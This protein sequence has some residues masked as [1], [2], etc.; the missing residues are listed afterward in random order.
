ARKM[1]FHYPPVSLMDAAAL[2][3][4]LRAKLDPLDRLTQWPKEPPTH[5]D[6]E[7]DPDWRPADEAHL[8]PAA[9]LAPIVK[10]AGGCTVLFTQRARDL[11][12]QG[13]Q[14]SFPG[15][16]MEAGETPLETALRETQEEIGLDRRFIEPVGGWSPYETGTGFRIVPIAGL[17]TG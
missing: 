6:F 7:I 14:I 11:R 4:L 10:R 17:V 13:G 3:Q 16:R 9:V 8:K 2:E 15:G 12:T 5:G 1:R